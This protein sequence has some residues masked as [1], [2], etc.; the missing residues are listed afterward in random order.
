MP[1]ERAVPL[2]ATVVASAMPGNRSIRSAARSVPQVWRAVR[3]GKVNTVTERQVR[4]W[5]SA[6]IEPVRIRKLLGITVGAL[7]KANSA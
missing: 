5:R 3:R 2:R 6:D 1:G 7:T 4:V